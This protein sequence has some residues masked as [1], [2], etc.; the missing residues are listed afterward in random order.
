MP[1]S[2]LTCN[3]WM[4]FLTR[5][6]AHSLVCIHVTKASRSSLVDSSLSY[7][8][9][10]M[11]QPFLCSETAVSSPSVIA[12]PLAMFAWKVAPA[13]ACGCTIVIKS[14]EQTPL[15]A[16]YAGQLALE[17]R[18]SAQPDLL[19]DACTASNAKTLACPACAIPRP[20]VPPLQI[21]TVWPL[22]VPGWRSPGRAECPLRVR[23]H[24]R[25]CTGEAHG[26]GQGEGPA[27]VAC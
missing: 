19:F 10:I 3:G 8:S 21:H 14:A 2:G 25:S 17:V 16:L 4:P 5:T 15:T 6:A 7:N 20:E 12:V 11:L 26:R 22:R 23:P 13:L 1:A 27:P 9:C 24:R 18:R